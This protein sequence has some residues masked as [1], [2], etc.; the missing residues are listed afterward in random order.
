MKIFADRI[1]SLGREKF[2]EFSQM[3]KF[4]FFLPV[5]SSF[6]VREKRRRLRCDR[7]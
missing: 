6:Q 7:H 3:G 5:D 2:P 4:T 1:Q